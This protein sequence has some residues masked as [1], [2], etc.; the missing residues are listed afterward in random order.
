MTDFAEYDEASAT[1]FVSKMNKCCCKVPDSGALYVFI[2]MRFC[3]YHISPS[4][5]RGMITQL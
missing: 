3:R 5:M 4:P 2:A 1:G